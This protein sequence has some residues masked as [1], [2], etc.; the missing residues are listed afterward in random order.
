VCSARDP[1]PRRSASSDPAANHARILSRESNPFYTARVISATPALRRAAQRNGNGS[2]GASA[3][4]A[5]VDH[6]NI[7]KASGQRWATLE[8][9]ERHQNGEQ[10]TGDLIM[11]KRPALTTRR[12]H[13]APADARLHFVREACPSEP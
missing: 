2:N 11:A 12:V 13:T 9:G 6:S 10:L 4:Q 8:A 5:C 3:P 1:L 7:A